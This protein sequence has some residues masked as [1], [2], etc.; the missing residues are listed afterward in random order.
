MHIN[1]YGEAHQLVIL[2][3]K[4]CF[5][6]NI[7]YISSCDISGPRNGMRR[8]EAAPKKNKFHY[9]L[10]AVLFAAALWYL[11]LLSGIVARLL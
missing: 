10:K 7:I 3:L 6:I 8:I 11:R 5:E 9:F 4:F 2:M 1:E